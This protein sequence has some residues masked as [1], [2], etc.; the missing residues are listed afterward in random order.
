MVTRWLRALSQKLTQPLL[1]ALL[2]PLFAAMPLLTHTGLPNTADGPVHLMRQVELNQAWQQG[3]Y[4]PRW[5]SDL[6]L[7]HGMPIFSYAPPALY[8][9]TQLLHSLGLA[10]DAAMKGVVILTFAGYSLGMFLF[11]RRILG[12]GPALVAASSYVYAPYRLR[13]AYIQG[14]YGQ[15]MGLAC[16]PFI[17]WAF[18]GLISD[19]RPRYLVASA[20]ALAALLFSHNISAM[21][22]APIFAAYLL[23]LLGLTL[24]RQS[25]ARPE[26]WPELL[27]RSGRTLLA[28][29]LGLGLAAIFWLPAFAERHD[30]KL[31]GLTQGFF[32]FRENFISLSEYFAWPRPLDLAA[33]NPE[34][35]LSL[36]W[37]QLIGTGLAGLGLGLLLS[38]K[39]SR[40]S[41]SLAPAQNLAV[42]AHAFFFTLFLLLYSF[43]ALPVSQSVWEA[44]PLLE[45]AEFPWRML[46]PAL[47]CAAFLGGLAFLV[48]SKLNFALRPCA[49]APLG[50]AVLLIVALLGPIALNA[51]YLF[52]SQFIP[53]GSPTPAEAFAYEVSSGA[54]GTTSTGEFLPR[55]AQQHPQAE[56]L[57]P[58]YQAGRPPGKLDPATLPAG[59]TVQTISHL[60]EAD[61][62]RI[63]TPEPFVAT[64]R[65]LYWPGWQIYLNGQ[66]APLTVTADTGLI[67]TE[68]PAGDHTLTLQLEPT[69]LRRIGQGLS[70]ASVAILL[71][72]TAL[73]AWPRPAGPA[74]PARVEH[75][76]ALA[77]G[78]YGLIGLLLIVTYLL[79]RPLAPWFTLQSDPNRPQPAAH[80]VEVDFG[81]QLR[82]VGFDELPQTVTPDRSGQAHLYPVLYWRA[83]PGLDKNYAVFVH[84]DAP[85]GQT[86]ATVDQAHPA[87]IPT[88]NWPAGLYLRNPLHLPVAADAPPI[89]YEVKVGVYDRAGGERLAV[90]N[91]QATTFSLGS[92]WLLPAQAEPAGPVVARYGPDLALYQPRLAG[93]LLQLT[94][95]TGQPL[96]P[97]LSIFI[98]LL[99]D[100]G[101]LVG[102]LDGA[103]Y[104]GLYPLADW[105]PQ[106]LIRDERFIPPDLAGLDQIAA[107]AIGIY[108]PVSGERL[109][110]V[111]DRGDLLPN[112]SYIYPVEP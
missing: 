86:F 73:A 72:V 31:E 87:D 48:W 36:G 110:A 50:P 83:W 27:R 43:L 111:D 69:P 23:F 82:L 47:F 109:A 9:A 35:P 80:H 53:W 16:Y 64:L 2:I 33:I 70:L 13:E 24:F 101:R 1:L 89:R 61:V 44:I 60:A 93:R 4:Y 25:A 71:G 55:G 95:Q 102:Q 77:P 37:P 54:I 10:L 40:R 22:F 46:G 85:N 32:D 92:L 51:Y 15:F 52:P 106:Q 49:P 42:L 79:S 112:D 28:G 78:P 59:A 76:P 30:I 75:P 66:P 81:R 91:G 94:W 45:L 11:S 65:T 6:A 68:I 90:A 20:L 56:T 7:G 84:L 99:D 38:R 62:L 18:H 100:Q 88:R 104:H 39:M 58:D 97:G 19:G 74:R 26:P 103:P 96:A 98:H 57:W 21:L 5:G 63:T 108:D 34:F 17:F 105:Y 12:P 107:L 3:N 14:N 67:Q 8:Q 29:S 41:I